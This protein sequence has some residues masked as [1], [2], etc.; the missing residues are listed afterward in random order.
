[1]EYKELLQKSVK[2]LHEL[3]AET[4][5]TVRELRFKSSERQLKNIRELRQLKKT[6]ARIQMTIQEKNAAKK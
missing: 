3:M 1:M 6:I 5:N 4:R 2:E